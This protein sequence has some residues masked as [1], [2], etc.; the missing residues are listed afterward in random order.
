MI[1]K[2]YDEIYLE[3]ATANFAVMMD[4]G[5]IISD[6]RIDEFYNRVIVSGT[7]SQFERGNPR[8]LVG[9]SGIELA[10]K[11][12]EDTGGTFR[13]TS[14]SSVEKTAEFWTGWALAHLQWSSG[15]SFEKIRNKGLPPEK[16]RQMYPLY[17]EADLSKFIAD[18]MRIIRESEEFP[19]S[20][21]KRQRKLAG[22]TQEQLSSLSGVSLRM[23]KAYE[24]R[25]QDLSRAEAR[26]LLNLSH[27][28]YCSPE[29]LI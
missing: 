21:L 14:Y 2:A 18:A 26:T 25:E 5:T 20:P 17:H 19:L 1:M 15:L 3:D 22:L 7:A 11:V 24:Q 10:W 29:T 8:F 6:G 28:L 4:Y 16:V 12:M 27:S 23:I 13:F 9:M